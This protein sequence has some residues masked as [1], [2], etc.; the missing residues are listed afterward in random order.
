MT[1]PS[2]LSLCICGWCLRIRY[3]VF[4]YFICLLL[5]FYYFIFQIL[6]RCHPT[7]MNCESIWFRLFFLFVFFLYSNFDSE[8][9]I[10][11]SNSSHSLTTEFLCFI[12]LLLVYRIWGAVESQFVVRENVGINTNNRWAWIEEWVGV[13]N[14]R[15]AKYSLLLCIV[16]FHFSIQQKP[17]QIFGLAYI[18]SHSSRYVVAKLI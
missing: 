7:L 14:G 17:E 10:C 8:S 12:Q 9:F 1:I 11:C 5:L 3:L 16:D 13:V 18:L 6:F 15:R 2:S 4:G